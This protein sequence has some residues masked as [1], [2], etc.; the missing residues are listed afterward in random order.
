MICCPFFWM[1][2]MAAASQAMQMAQRVANPRAAWERHARFIDRR[3]RRGSKE[4][5]WARQH[6]R[7]MIADY[8][9]R[10]RRRRR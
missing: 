3:Y 7:E 1:G 10:R 4:W 2:Y 9:G 5:R 8:Y 6:A